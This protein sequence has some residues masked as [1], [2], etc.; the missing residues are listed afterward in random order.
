M[1]IQT[2]RERERERGPYIYMYIIYIYIYIDLHIMY[3]YTCIYIQGPMIVRSS[4]PSS[5]V[6]RIAGSWFLYIIRIVYGG[7]GTVA[8]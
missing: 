8:N 4:L 3:I 2:E 1:Y 7:P 6:T 5:P